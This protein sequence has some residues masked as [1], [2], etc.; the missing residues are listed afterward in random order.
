MRQNT[1]FSLV[2]AARS[3]GKR[4][5]T[6]EKEIYANFAKLAEKCSHDLQLR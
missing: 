1:D 2:F 3:G 5:T 6:A 4:G